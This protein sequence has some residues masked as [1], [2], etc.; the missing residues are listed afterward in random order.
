MAN[1]A[2]ERDKTFQRLR[3]VQSQLEEATQHI[4]QPVTA[5]K[6][7]PR[8]M[9]IGP[10]SILTSTVATKL[11]ATIIEH[12]RDRLIEQFRQESTRRAL[13]NIVEATSPASTRRTG[14]SKAYAKA[15]VA[16]P[17]PEALALLHKAAMEELAV[18]EHNHRSWRART[19][20]RIRATYDRWRRSANP[21][22][23]RPK[24]PPPE[25]APP[26]KH[27]A[28]QPVPPTPQSYAQPARVT[29]FPVPPTPSPKPPGPSLPKYAALY[30]THAVLSGM[31][32]QRKIAPTAI[33]PSPNPF[34]EETPKQ[35][36]VVKPDL[37]VDETMLKALGK[38]RL[39]KMMTSM[40]EGIDNLRDAEGNRIPLTNEIMQLALASWDETY[41]RN[42]EM[43][44]ELYR[45][46]NLPLPAI[47]LPRSVKAA[48]VAPNG[49]TDL[50]QTAPAAKA[51]PSP[52]GQ[53]TTEQPQATGPV[54]PTAPAAQPVPPPA[55]RP[56]APPPPVESLPT[57]MLTPEERAYARGDRAA[58]QRPV[59][60]VPQAEPPIPIP[61]PPRASPVEAVPA[62]ATP[63]ENTAPTGKELP[64]PGPPQV[65][66]P[67]P[68]KTPI[69]EPPPQDPVPPQLSF[70]DSVKPR[71]LNRG[72]TFPTPYKRTERTV[73][74]PAKDDQPSLDLNTPP[75]GL[76]D[77]AGRSTTEPAQPA[78]DFTENPATKPPTASSTDKGAEEE[79]E[80]TPEEIARRKKIRDQRRA[81]LR[82]Q[83]GR[84][85]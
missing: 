9:W 20:D 83:K 73:A 28:T 45:A 46:K 57:R 34:L 32:E 27:P 15:D 65:P 58:T 31:T 53:Q 54:T 51:S 77:Q 18:F 55:P 29:P 19:A 6:H 36:G 80:L 82:N 52:A 25:Q 84:G 69:V 81:I 5:N 47:L 13:V 2:I 10:D 76:L 66:T 38:N 16:P 75:P 1:A 8:S 85:R 78:P 33:S 68:A 40:L 22:D 50:N 11:V 70:L 61:T 7:L 79:K 49:T 42:R 21:S 62:P 44:A 64:P 3:K 71:P 59:T 30:Q 4:R 72:H 48:P 35:S 60:P 23:Y 39:N 56:Q 67:I 26:P 41:R 43:V 14:E 12:E 17:D 24:A 74:R 63:R 37:T